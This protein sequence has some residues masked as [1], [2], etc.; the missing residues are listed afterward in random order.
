MELIKKKKI[1]SHSVGC[2]FVWITKYSVIHYTLPKRSV[3]WVLYSLIVDLSS[4][5][6]IDVLFKKSS[7]ITMSSRLFPTF[8]YIRFY[9]S[10]F[11]LFRV[12]DKDLFAFFC[13]QISSLISWRCCLFSNVSDLFIKS[14]ISIGLCIYLWLQLNSIDQHVCFYARTMKLLLL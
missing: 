6:A 9:V 5:W 3:S 7:P 11:M 10:G 4:V 8:S 2:H 1:F 12:T 13:M 14:K